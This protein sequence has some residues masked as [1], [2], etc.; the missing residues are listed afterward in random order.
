MNYFIL[1][2]LSEC[3]LSYRTKS[4]VQ[5]FLRT[6]GYRL[7]QNELKRGYGVE[8]PERLNATRIQ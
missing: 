3:I 4:Q 6:S 5:A 7:K 2:T 8:F 1:K